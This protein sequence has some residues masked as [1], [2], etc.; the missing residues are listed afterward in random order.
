MEQDVRNVRKN[1]RQV[2]EKSQT[3]LA[4]PAWRNGSGNSWMLSPQL[5]NE[6]G[7]ESD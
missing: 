3:L 4:L 2:R 6:K 7:E 5:Q 1:T